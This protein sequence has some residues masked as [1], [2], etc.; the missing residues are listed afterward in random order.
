MPL[1]IDEAVQHPMMPRAD[2]G[3][4]LFVW[5]FWPT[6]C[7]RHVV[8]NMQTPV[9]LPGTAGEEALS[10]GAEYAR[11]KL[12]PGLGVVHSGHW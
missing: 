4:A 11:A 7:D 10:F 12:P 8:M 5:H 6:V 2:E 3:D 9:A 1:P